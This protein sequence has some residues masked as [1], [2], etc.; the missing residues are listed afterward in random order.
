M[1]RDDCQNPNL[2]ELHKKYGKLP[3]VKQNYITTYGKI[4]EKLMKNL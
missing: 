4:N 1:D 2:F 3:E